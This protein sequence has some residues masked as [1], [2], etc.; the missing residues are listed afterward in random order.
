MAEGRSAE[1]FVAGWLDKIRINT[2][3]ILLKGIGDELCDLGEVIHPVY[4][5]CEKTRMFA[6]S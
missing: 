6:T 2:R 5:V 3:R 1:S 4:S